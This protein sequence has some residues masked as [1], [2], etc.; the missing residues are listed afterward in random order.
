LQF[1]RQNRNQIATKSCG[2]CTIRCCLLACHLLSHPIK[3]P[4]CEILHSGQYWQDLRRRAK[5]AKAAR[6]QREAR[7]PSTAPSDSGHVFTFVL[8]HHQP[9]TGLVQSSGKVV[10]VSN[11]EATLQEQACVAQLATQHKKRH[12]AAEADRVA[13]ANRLQQVRVDP[14]CASH[15]LISISKPRTQIRSFWRV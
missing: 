6:A 3:M 1:H 13:R 12:Q 7:T 8:G 9:Y 14:R 4:K 5:E 2:E 11:P 10:S 15:N